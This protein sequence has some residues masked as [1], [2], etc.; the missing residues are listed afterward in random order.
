MAEIAVWLLDFVIPCFNHKNSLAHK[1][2]LN[3]LTKEPS[4]P[5]ENLWEERNVSLHFSL[6]SKHISTSRRSLGSHGK[7]AAALEDH[8]NSQSLTATSLTFPA[9]LIPGLLQFSKTL[10]LNRRKSGPCEGLEPGSWGGC[11]QQ[12]KASDLGCFGRD[13]ALWAEVCLQP[14]HQGVRH[15]AVYAQLFTKYLTHAHILVLQGK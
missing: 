1:L 4:I 8:F 14:L 2:G 12:P 3:S 9:W 13:G 7:P 6:E 15:P 5:G 10:H 11:V